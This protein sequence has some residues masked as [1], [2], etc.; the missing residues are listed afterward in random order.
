MRWIVRAL[1]MVLTLAM[2]AL[3]ALWLIPSETVARAASAEIARLTGRQVAIEGGLSP[4]IWPVLGLRT[5]PVT[6]AGAAW[7]DAGP[8]LRADSIDIGIDP[9]AALGGEVRVKSLDLR[10]LD[11]TLEVAAD[12]R[13]NWDTAAA[14]PASGAA[15]SAPA[16]PTVQGAP[17][18]IERARLSGRVTFIDRSAGRR[19]AVEALEA[20]LRLPEDGSGAAEVLG[21]V[22]GAALRLALTTPEAAALIAG[23]VA[24]V[25]ASGAVGGT[26]FAFEG[27]AGWSPAAA[28]GQLSAVLADLRGIAAL[29][30]MAVPD[31]PEGMGRRIR[32]IAG[33]VTLA[34][35]GSLHLRGG[36]AV[37]D[38]NR[39]SFAAD[40][41]FDGP[42]PRL[43][44]QIEGGALILPGLLPARAPAI[45]GS[46]GGGGGAPADAGWSRAAIDVSAL[47]LLD[48]E[49]ALR[50]AS[51]DL[52][53]VRTGPLRLRIT[54]DRARAVIEAREAQVWGGLIG[55]QFVVNGRSGLSVGGDLTFA[56]LALGDA[57]R[58]LV[59]QDRLTTTGELRLKFLGVG[60]S[61]AAIMASLSGEGQLALG[62]GEWRGFDLLGMLRTLDVGYVG[63]GSRTV[64]D[65]VTGRFAMQ[66][67]VLSSDDL[68][69][70]APGLTA[71]ATGTLGLGAQVLDW[72]ITPTALAKADGTGGVKVPLIVSGPWSAP[73]FR[74]DLKALADQELAEER[75][76][77]EARAREAE[78]RAKAE[79]ERKAAEE[80]GIVRQQG[81]SL[82]DAA[83]RR[84]EE[85]LKREA[86]RALGRLLGGN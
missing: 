55:G 25:S 4:R 41:S 11:L 64:F 70:V 36:E 47:G 5:G 62:R 71:A 29:T 2:L 38:G 12:G 27:R 82:E 22:D 66:D 78:A 58:D 1:A 75:A 42:R 8:L 32:E 35:A 52:G 49:I 31:L 40:L 50:A 3:G 45:A 16:A 54:L 21:R 51:A 9:M 72:R 86:E 24:P 61:V 6:V 81:E 18:V 37:L 39:L 26:N 34:P 59:G 77:L 17:P 60:N 83:K 33:Q 53:R 14:P 48:A 84:A 76:R 57:L 20:T 67:G 79:L 74:L 44:A 63:E 23:R 7:S 80:L 65:S 10:G 73:R 56:G 13:V 46:G 15:P 19:L 69:L 68:R 43:A 28:E 30:G 85:A